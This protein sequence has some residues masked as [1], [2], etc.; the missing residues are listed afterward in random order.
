MRFGARATILGVLGALA[1]CT[2]AHRLGGLSIGRQASSAARALA[3]GGAFGRAHGGV[4]RLSAPAVRDARARRLAARVRRERWRQGALA[5]TSAPPLP[6]SPA[7]RAR[8]AASMAVP[9]AAPVVEVEAKVVAKQRAA[10]TPPPYFIKKVLD[11]E[12]LTLKAISINGSPLPSEAYE[13]TV[14]NKPRLNTG[15][16]GLYYSGAMLCT[17][18]EAEGFRRIT[19]FQ[20]RM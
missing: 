15:L 8:T 20:V 9:A 19:F 1:P 2:Q 7:K 12:E 6:I 4:A 14:R 16:S 11:G 17:Q 5:L 10:Y 13:T 3:L 18:C